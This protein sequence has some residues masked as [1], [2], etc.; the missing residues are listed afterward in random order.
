MPRFD[1]LSGPALS[2]IGVALVGYLLGSLPF[3]YWVAK[4]RGTN[5]FEA[6]SRSS[7]AT[8]VG[9]VLGRR[10]G[11][12]VFVL[13]VLKGVA[14]AGWPLAWKAWAGGGWPVPG[15]A[16]FPNPAA[17][18]EGGL[19]LGVAGLIGALIGHSF[20]CLTGFRGGKG[21][22]TG[23]G[24]FLVLMP[25]VT[26][27]GGAVWTT[28]FL[29]TRY[30]SLA[31]LAAAITLPVASVVL[32]EPVLLTVISSL[33]AVFV[34]VRHRGNIARLLSGTEHRWSRKRGGAE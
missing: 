5:I 16:G 34:G 32:R 11:Y 3:G 23:A 9:R 1:S 17:G 7:G 13:D 31:S 25:L 28:L 2:L 8:N 6:G 24:G 4:A 26:L 14:A 12:A 15:P 10:V 33:I 20:S 30:V 29:A 18:H 22:A 21:V 19:I 27:I